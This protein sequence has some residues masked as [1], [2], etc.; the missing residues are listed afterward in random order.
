MG[1]EEF[2]SGRAG[3]GGKE[4]VQFSSGKRREGKGGG[5]EGTDG[6]REGGRE[7]ACF[8]LD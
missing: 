8:G 7:G 6:G 2:T 4:G 3:G 1:W 5:G